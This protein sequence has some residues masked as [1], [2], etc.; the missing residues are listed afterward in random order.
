MTQPGLQNPHALDWV[1]G[2]LD[3][4]LKQASQSLEFYVEDTGDDYELANCAESLHQV[5]GTLRLVELAGAVRYAEEMA[6]LLE[7]VREERIERSEAIFEALMRGLLQLPAY[8]EYIQSG[9][10]DLPQALL[11]EINELR[12]LAGKPPLGAET[13]VHIAL[14][15]EPPAPV[16]PP[17]AS[18]GALAAKARPNYQRALV[19]WLKNSGDANAMRVLLRVCELVRQ[20]AREPVQARL[21]WAATGLFVGLREGAIEADSGAK[22]LLTALDRQ[23]KSLAAGEAA[24]E[25]AETLTRRILY[26][27][28]EAPD[29]GPETRELVE[30]FGLEEVVPSPELVEE[31]ERRLHGPD[32][33]VLRSV[34]QAVKEDLQRARDVIEIFGASSDADPSDLAPLRDNLRRMAD[35]LGMM[36]LNS[37]ADAV[38]EQRQAVEAM[39]EGRLGTEEARVVDVAEVLLHVDTFLLELADEKQRALRVTDVMAPVPAVGAGGEGVAQARM[40]D[41]ETR[42]VARAFYAVGLQELEHVRAAVVGE[43]DDAGAVLADQPP[44]LIALAGGVY[45]LDHEHAAH[46]LGQLAGVLEQTVHDPLRDDQLEALADAITALESALESYVSGQAAGRYL[47][48]AEERLA[49]LIGAPQQEAPAATDD[50][51]DAETAERSGEAS[52]DI[53]I[54]IDEIDATL[55]TVECAPEAEQAEPAAEE[56]EEAGSDTEEAEP[57]EAEPA[58]EALEEA[59]SDEV[60]AAVSDAVDVDGEAEAAE[61]L[62]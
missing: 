18:L 37:L 29:A 30:A 40:T 16:E 4:T 8:L 33:A 56:P 36:G 9:G 25:P 46:L 49:G 27:V 55:P 48:L 22:Q 5:I 2:E 13:L 28:A 1:K 7:A 58:G 35:T 43:G 24:G 54:D 31:V 53:D 51:L 59:G 50:E 21:W 44:R 20:V 42:Q 32:T 61:A 23:L 47:E 26:R 60:A 3:E 38:R 34:G 12:R 19:A 17:I 52:V 45:M 57:V 6:S 14:D 11:P 62:A 10:R 39:T 15:A 41:L